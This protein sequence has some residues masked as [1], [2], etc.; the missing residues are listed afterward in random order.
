[1]ETLFLQYIHW[2]GWWAYGLVFIG[3]IAEGETFLF[4]AIY[5]AHLR[6]FNLKILL[7]VVFLG[8]IFSDFFW[9]FVGE[10]LE[11]KSKFVSKWMGKI[12]KPLDNKLQ[13]RPT[14]TI[15]IAR[16]AYGIYHATLMRAGALKIPLK[17]Y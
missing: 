14:I 12:S 11:R 15:F 6:Y 9:Y 1:M 2:M 4:A 16:F 13:K 3:M 10:F 17:L 5:L 8:L 7:A